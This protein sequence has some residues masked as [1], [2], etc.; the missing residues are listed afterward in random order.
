M[1]ASELYNLFLIELNKLDKAQNVRIDIGKFV[2]LYNRHQLNFCRNR[3]RSTEDSD[4]V[5]MQFLLTPPVLLKQRSKTETYYLFD[6]PNDYLRWGSFH[7][8][9]SKG[10]CKNIALYNDLM[11]AQN[12]NVVLDDDS[13][14]PSFEFEHVPVNFLDNALQVFYK[15][16]EVEGQFLSYYRKPIEI[17]IE[18]YINSNGLLSSTIDPEVPEWVSTAVVSITAVTAHNSSGNTEMAQIT[19]MSNKLT[20]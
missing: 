14:R 12:L 4:V 16:F 20:S 1:T 19:A 13:H 17:D 3:I 11:K 15:D 9:A 10:N 6:L 7:T 2:L 18:G 5:D 8:V